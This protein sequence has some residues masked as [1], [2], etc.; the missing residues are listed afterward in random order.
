MEITLTPD[1]EELIVEQ[2]ENGR[3]RSPGEVVRDALQLLKQRLASREQELQSLGTKT[4]VGLQALT[5]GDL[6]E[7]DSGDLEQLAEEVKAQGRKRLA[8]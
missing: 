7:Y 3:Y 8:S 1:L 4:R 2:V 5:N 6:S